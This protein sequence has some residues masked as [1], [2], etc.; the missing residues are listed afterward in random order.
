VRAGAHRPDEANRHSEHGGL[1]KWDVAAPA[2]WHFTQFN[3]DVGLTEGHFCPHGGKARRIPYRS[4]RAVIFDSS[5]FHETAIS[6]LDRNIAS[7]GSTSRCCMRGEAQLL[8]MMV[9]S[10]KEFGKQ[11]RR[12][13]RNRAAGHI[14][15]ISVQYERHGA[16][17]KPSAVT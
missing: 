15:K 7:G 5:L 2:D 17:V 9:V 16:A 4:N 14:S 8:K 13:S 1:V 6:G 10:D 11:I 12:S 3:A